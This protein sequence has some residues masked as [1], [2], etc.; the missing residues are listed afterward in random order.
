MV[1]NNNKNSTKGSLQKHVFACY[2][3]VPIFMLSIFK[4][5]FLLMHAKLFEKILFP[6]L[7][8]EQF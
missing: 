7:L 5:I 4:A 3:K 1:Y 2:F 6:T 8:T